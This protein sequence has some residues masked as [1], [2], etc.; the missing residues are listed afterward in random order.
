MDS[1]TRI[2][3][4]PEDHGRAGD[5]LVVTKL[6]RLARSPPGW[7]SRWRIPTPTRTRI[8]TSVPI[9]GLSYSGWVPLLRGRTGPGDG[10][11]AAAGQPRIGM[12]FLTTRSSSQRTISAK[13]RRRWL[14]P[15]S[16][17]DS[18]GDPLTAGG[19]RRYPPQFERS[20]RVEG[21]GPTPPPRPA[22]SALAAAATHPS[23]TGPTTSHRP[24]RSISP[25]WTVI[26]PSCE[27]DMTEQPRRFALPDPPSAAVSEIGPKT[28][29]VAELSADGPMSG[30]G[31]QVAVVDG[32]CPLRD[33]GRNCV[34]GQSPGYQY[35]K[36]RCWILRR[37]L[38]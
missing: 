32:P 29:R 27:R 24:A 34:V 22:P 35:D 6:D 12:P 14:T 37:R 31:V 15:R 8:T 26:W 4:R 9:S 30:N 17:A 21:G 1:E 19:P 28:A 36:A 11:R 23:G 7:R 16:E 10:D 18:G 13:F 25:S 3:T 33:D 20:R 38:K 5:V 2:A